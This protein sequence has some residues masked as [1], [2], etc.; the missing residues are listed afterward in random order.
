MKWASEVYSGQVRETSVG[1]VP[2]NLQVCVWHTINLE[3]V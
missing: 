3:R 2:G 1:E